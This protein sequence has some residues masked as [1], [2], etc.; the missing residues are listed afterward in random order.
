MENNI[1]IQFE[2]IIMN[3]INSIFPNLIKNDKL[4]LKTYMTIL[5][6]VIMLLFNST[7]D[8][9]TPNELFIQQFSQNNYRETKWLLMQLLPYISGKTKN[10]TELKNILITK[11]VPVNINKIEPKYKYSNIQYG[12]F[13]RN[14]NNFTEFEDIDSYMKHNFYLLINTIK[15]ISHKLFPNWINIFPYSLKDYKTSPLFEE[16][17]MIYASHNLLEWNPTDINI[18]DSIEEIINKISNKT[19]YLDMNDI[20]NTISII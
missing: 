11:E 18:S 8:E 2:L 6:N 14:K 4:K 9:I 16:T 5:L 10:I 3:S 7:G 13:F 20:Y 12:R 1:L 19:N 15:T 17:Q